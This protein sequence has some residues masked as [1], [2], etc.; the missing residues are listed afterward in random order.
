MNSQTITDKSRAVMADEIRGLAS[1]Y[2][3]LA[4]GER[5]GKKRDFYAEL[6]CDF[7][8]LATALKH[9]ES[10]EEVA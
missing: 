1:K 6:S 4:H 9:R 3:A 8:V 5:N 10:F 2:R 7:S